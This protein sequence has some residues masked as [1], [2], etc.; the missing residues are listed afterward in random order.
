MKKKLSTL[1]FVVLVTLLIFSGLIACNNSTSPQKLTT[2]IVT[3]NDNVATWEA[4]TNAD[5]FEISLDGT[6]SYVENS[7]TSKTLNNGQTFKIRA[8]GD[9]VNY[10]TSDWSNSVTYTV[11][12]QNPQATKLGTP[13]V[14]IS[15][16]GLASWNAVPNANGYVYK[17][18][19]GNETSISVTQIQLTDGQ[20]ITVK[21]VGDG[22]NY[23]D[24]DFS[25]SKTY[26]EGQVVPTNAPTYL[27]ILASNNEPTK[28]DG[29]PDELISNPTRLS[30][31]SA[32][33]YRDF[34]TALKEYFENGD[35]RFDENYPTESN[36]D[37][38][39]RAGETVYI[40]IWLNNPEQH[41]IISLKLNGTKYQVG[42][43]LSSFFIEKDN[44]HYNCLY[45][46]LTI[47]SGSYVEKEYTVTDIEYIANTFINADGTDEFM[48]DNDTVIIG[49][50]YQES[51]PS[52]TNY[53]QQEV[54]CNNYQAS[55]NLSDN[56]LANVSGA[57]L[58]VAIYDSEQSYEI[59]SNQ[60]LVVGENIIQV[61][62]LVENS[63]YTVIVYLYG[64]L[65]DGNG[66]R[67]HNLY[68]DWITTEE[69]LTYNEANGVIVLN[70]KGTGY[71]GAVKVNTTLNSSTASYVKLEILN[72]DDQVVYTDF[73]YN[74][75]AVVTDGILNKANYTV[76]VHYKDNE[77]LDGRYVDEWIYVAKLTDPSVENLDYYT[78]VNDAIYSFEMSSYSDNYAGVDGLTVKFYDAKSAQ[79][80]AED[81]ISL[82][83]NENL[84]DELW[85]EYWNLFDEQAQYE[86]ES[87]ESI[88]IGVQMEEIYNRISALNQ[89]ENVWEN[90]F[91]GND[92]KEFWQLEAQKGKYYYSY[93]YSGIDTEDIFKVDNRYYVILKNIDANKWANVEIVANVVKNESTK[94]GGIVVTTYQLGT[95]TLRLE[96]VFNE[97]NYNCMELNGDANLD[98]NSFTFTLNN[99]HDRRIGN[100]GETSSNAK[101]Q[102]VYKVTANGKK[103]YSSDTIKTLEVNEEDWI[104]EYILNAKA[105]TLDAVALYK[106]YMPKYSEETLTLDYT[107]IE[108]GKYTFFVHTRMYNKEYK[109]G[110]GES[111]FEV[112]D[113]E[114]F[115]KLD[116]PTLTMEGCYGYI[117]LPS[118]VNRE[119]IR[120]EAYDSENKEIKLTY[121]NVYWND[122]ASS[123]RFDFPYVGAKVRIKLSK[124]PISNGEGGES[125]ETIYWYDSDWTEYE[126]STAK[127]LTSPT[128]T[129]EGYNNYMVR[130]TFTDSELGG[131]FE[132]FVYTVNGGEEITGN[133]INFNRYG[134]GTYVIKVKAVVNYYGKE[135]GYTDSD[136][137]TYTHTYQTESSDKG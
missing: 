10:S 78:F 95:S 3:L 79:Y 96:S 99:S 111:C 87:E 125:T 15:G 5:R 41:S 61:N 83:E 50:S 37:I 59:I 114:I 7:M 64:D 45:V 104:E 33:T 53:N 74:G 52:I 91:E 46:T 133:S 14:T 119:D 2:P 40:Q 80:I 63:H 62:G 4:N 35:N 120:F 23:L 132:K 28:A 136:W 75:S 72:T 69:A 36:Y 24:S 106:K 34:N 84:I 137:V 103:L 116:T 122:S 130:F 105:G 97:R 22:I 115:K 42:G 81:V 110:N 126:N 121:D 67:V 65:H 108:A 98:E 60:E 27:G 56:A 89:V 127:Y 54:T 47:P 44:E 90:D 57:W 123:Y 66:V 85:A 13:T 82:I 76:R 20:S 86:S 102:Y 94:N 131:Y 9:G 17:I 43:G 8:V 109:D 71:I 6:L 128:V 92:D 93:T 134:S 31:A 129:T 38:Y 25:T 118:S 49:L 19:N 58:G 29:I 112:Y 48:N 77:Y 51:Y 101:K 70:S 21:A 26:T 113:M 18:N 107:E 100:S 55:F 30:L 39:S 12:T 124:M 11:Q 117:V 68:Y 1:S 73:E 16:S 135:V 88:A 32:R